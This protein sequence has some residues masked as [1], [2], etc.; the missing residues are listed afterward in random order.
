MPKS[1]S[2]STLAVAATGRP[3]TTSAVIEVVDPSGTSAT[4]IRSSLGEPVL[5]CE[6]AKPVAG[7]KFAV[8]QNALCIGISMPHTAGTV[9]VRSPGVPVSCAELSVTRPT[10]Q[11]IQ[12]TTTSPSGARLPDVLR[13]VSTTSFVSPYVTLVFAVESRSRSVAAAVTVSAVEPVAPRN[14]AFSANAAVIVYDPGSRPP[15]V[16]TENVALPSMQ[17]HGA[18]RDR[19][20]GGRH[21]CHDDRGAVGGLGVGRAHGD[22]VVRRRCRR[23]GCR[24]P[25]P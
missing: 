3:N 5:S 16:E 10:S 25:A 13:M 22:R 7:S 6:A 14:C 9:T 17:R 8:S 2:T 21:R 23:R 11:P 15:T 19:A 20:P 4:M 12:V 24:R 18:E 1:P